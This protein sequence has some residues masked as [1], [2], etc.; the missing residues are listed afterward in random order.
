MHHPL[1]LGSA[2]LLV[3]SWAV[4]FGAAGCGTLFPSPPPSKTDTQ[5]HPVRINSLG[6]LPESPKIATVIAP[7]GPTFNVRSAADDSVAWSSMMGTKMTDELTG[8]TLFQADFSAFGTAGS[9]YIEVPGLGRSA[10]FTVGADV[11]NNLLTRAM[12]GMYGQRCGTDVH[13]T[14][15][16]E[17]WGHAACHLHDG[18]LKYLTGSTDVQASIGGW[19]DAG[20]YGKYTT[21][22]AFSAGMMLA[23]WEQFQPAVSTLSLP[24]P[25]HGGAFPDFLA[26]V[27]WELDWLLTI[28]AP[29]GSG[30]IPHKLTALNFEGFI[31][32]ETDT[33]TRY[34]T[35]VGTAATADFVAVMAQAA[36]IY[37]PYDADFAAKCLAAARLSY[38]LPA[39]EHRSGGAE[40]AGL[41][42]GRLRRQQRQRRADVGRCRALG[43]HRRGGLPDRL[44]DAREQGIAVPH[45]RLAERRQPGHVHVSAVE[46]RRPQPHAGGVA[47]VLAEH[48]CRAVGPPGDHQ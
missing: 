20:D 1:R 31:M 25:E 41:Q 29:D 46:A 10:T 5:T 3:S 14:L 26:E 37:Q 18:A 12:I 4:S 27:K 15:D 2:F 42:H 44:R 17:T 30:G 36:R 34:F 8:D 40:H 43:D 39:V 23:A 47:L 7:G 32:P 11:Y 38:T 45:V 9:F 19:H 22:G 13:I 24:I 35:P 16:G 48:H 6:Y 28:P 33:S 21:N